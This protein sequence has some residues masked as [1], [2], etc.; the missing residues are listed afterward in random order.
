MHSVI[1][2]RSQCKLAMRNVKI[3]DQVRF[4]YDSDS[5]LP[6]NA[7]Q[8][9]ITIILYLSLMLYTMLQNVVLV[10]ICL[11]H[12]RICRH[13]KFTCQILNSRNICG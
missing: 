6:V 9:L 7:H 10:S 8:N 4:S 5:A 13:V 2:I 11:Q 12:C 3:Y 1:T